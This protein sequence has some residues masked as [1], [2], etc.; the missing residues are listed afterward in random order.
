MK[1]DEG[2][3]FALSRKSGRMVDITMVERGLGCDCICLHCGAIL[4]ARK[5]R[6]NRHHF[7]HYVA[8]HGVATCEGGS[9]SALHA[10]ARELIAQ[11]RSIELPA[12]LVD[13][14]GR[15]R[16][17]PGRT[18]AVL[19]S[20]LPD[21]LGGGAYWGRDKVRPDVVLHGHTEQIWCEVKVTHAVGDQK[22][23]RLQRC[24]VATLEFDLSALHRHG[25]WTRVSLEHALRSDDR[26]RQWAFHPEEARL[27]QELR[28]ENRAAV[29]QH[30]RAA[31]ALR[32]GT[33]RGKVI[34]Q[35][36]NEDAER[37]GLNRYD[38]APLVFHPALGLVPKDPAKRLA[39]IAQAY[40]EPKVYRLARA[41]AFLRNHPHADGTCLVS[42]GG[43]GAASRTS[44]YDAALSE[45]A[46]SAGLRCVYFGI[47]ESRQVR[48]MR[49]Y[50]QLDGFLSALQAEEAVP[51]CRAPEPGRHEK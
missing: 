49:C 40:P 4:Q 42:F 18:L 2:L 35:H 15:Q 51:E 37:M 17:L 24:N 48:G 6:K 45:F 33:D 10:A 19:R 30:R 1:N 47:P 28:A 5:G 46:R 20:E 21:D 3:D 25:G 22:R 31:E 13:E 14:G 44:E 34:A 9:E 7:A 11:W 36:G 39:F 16:S 50:Q 27:K 41:V 29:A 32:V 23:A 38:G 26:L 43:A 12:L 8:G